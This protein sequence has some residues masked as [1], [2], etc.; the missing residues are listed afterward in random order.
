ME[1]A[2]LSKERQELSRSQR[3]L[4]DERSVRSSIR[5]HTRTQP[6][7]RP[8]EPFALQEIASERARLQ[9]ER[10][11]WFEEQE[12]MSVAGSERPMPTYYHQ[13]IGPGL[14]AQRFKDNAYVTTSRAR[15]CR[16]ACRSTRSSPA[17]NMRPT[18]SPSTPNLSAATAGLHVD[19]P[20]Q[21]QFLQV[22]E[23][24]RA[25]TLQELRGRHAK[26]VQSNYDRVGTNHKELTVSRGEYLEV[27]NDSKNWWECRN[28]Q[29]RVGFV[30]HTILTVIAPG[31]P[32]GTSPRV[33][34][35]DE[36]G[37][38]RWTNKLSP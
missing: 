13:D 23:L 2:T 20:R 26:I 19:S 6:R 21:Q 1:R 32:Q 11:R 30:P 4:A 29:N 7:C 34:G 27:L 31:G 8:H 17:P 25:A 38:P 10:R 3:Q 16:R 35:N 15:P 14:D 33:S 36:V 28:V 12:R 9:D 24:R 5:R 37:W 22:R 18:M